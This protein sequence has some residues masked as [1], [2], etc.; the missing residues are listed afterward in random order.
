LRTPTCEP[1]KDTFVI[2]RFRV[3]AICAGTATALCGALARCHGSDL[4]P[5]RLPFAHKPAVFFST[6]PTFWKLNEAC[7]PQI[8]PGSNAH[9]VPPFS[10]F[11]LADSFEPP[12]PP[13]PCWR[14]VA[15]LY[16]LGNCDSPKPE[17]LLGYLTRLGTVSNRSSPLSPFFAFTDSARTLPEELVNSASAIRPCGFTLEESGQP[18][19]P[20]F[21]PV[22]W[23]YP[24]DLRRLSF[25]R[26]DSKFEWRV[27]PFGSL[28]PNQD[29]TPPAASD[30]AILRDISAGTSDHRVRLVFCP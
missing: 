8:L 19:W 14:T 21:S 6:S 22:T 3:F 5:L 28:F 10:V 7:L 20:D 25:V 26:M 16:P 12:E 1:D 11:G 27:E 29:S 18:A 13:A 17:T 15:T 24:G 30:R 2:S 9:F 23:D 4:L